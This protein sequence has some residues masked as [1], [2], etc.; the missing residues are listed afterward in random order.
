VSLNQLLSTLNNWPWLPGYTYY[1]AL[2]NTSANPENLQFAMSFPSD[3]APVAFLAPTTV[4]STQALPAIQVVW[5]VTN[6]GLALAPGGWFDRVWFSTNGGLN[7]H[8]VS[9]GDFPFYQ[10]VPPGGSY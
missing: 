8:S 6:Q 5:G 10:S 4:T 1:L 3:L 9:I 2:T 7:A